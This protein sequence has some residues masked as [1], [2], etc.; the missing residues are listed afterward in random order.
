MYTRQKNRNSLS[1]SQ[2]SIWVGQKMSEQSPLYNMANTFVI[3]GHILPDQFKKAF[4]ILVEETEVMRTV[5]SEY[6]NGTPYQEVLNDYTYPLVYYDYSQ[7]SEEEIDEIILAR[8]KQ[9]FDLSQPPFDSVLIKADENK[10]VWL[11]NMHHLITDVST[12]QILFQRMG[13][14]FL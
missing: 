8:A 3:K 13:K 9:S 11:L 6:E 7:L 5:F 2:L 12:T 1:N 10:F 4:Q 14:V